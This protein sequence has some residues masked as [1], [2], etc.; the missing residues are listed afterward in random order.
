[1]D[2]LDHDRSGAARGGVGE[3][4]VPVVRLAMDGNE[5]LARPESTA[6]GRDGGEA[7]RVAD[8]DEIAARGRQDLV[9]PEGRPSALDCRRHAGLP[10]TRR[11]SSRSSRWCL[12]APTIW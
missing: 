10:R 9:E 2:R 3:K 4:L 11:T 5:E 6:V 7:E 1:M 8:A 12:S